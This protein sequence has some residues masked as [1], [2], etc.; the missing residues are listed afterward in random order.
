MKDLTMGLNKK[1]P[2]ES[3]H[4]ANSLTQEATFFLLPE[5]PRQRQYEA[6][7]AYFVEGL[8][9]KEVAA[10]FGSRITWLQSP[11]ASPWQPLLQPSVLP[12]IQRPA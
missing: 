7:R 1:I 10:R 9:V 6:L 8:P 4:L 11:L 5:R 3:V 2:Q 12:L